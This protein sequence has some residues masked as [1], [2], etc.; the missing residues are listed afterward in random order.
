MRRGEEGGG[1][2][3]FVEGDSRI[4]IG[5]L[6]RMV[7]YWYIY[8]YKWERGLWINSGR[9]GKVRVKTRWWY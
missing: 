2:K 3:R 6:E 8:G 7:R 9:N 4:Y 5:K 1:R